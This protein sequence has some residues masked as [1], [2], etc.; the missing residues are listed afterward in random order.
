MPW[1]FGWNDPGLSVD[2]ALHL[3]TLVALVWF[4]W[5]EWITLATAFFR[6]LRTRRIETESERRVVWVAIAT[7]PGAIAGVAL[8]DYAETVFRSPQL[9][10]TMLIIMGVVGLNLAGSH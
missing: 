2:V 6:I 7:V 3:G 9:I 5:Q 4:F 1:L 10:G 8:K